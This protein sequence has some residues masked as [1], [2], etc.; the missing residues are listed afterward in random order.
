[1]EEISERLRTVASFVPKGA[2]LLDVGSDH[3][4]LPLYLLDK[5]Q[6]SFALAGEV[7]EGPY[8]SALSHV[9]QSA[10]KEGIEVRLAD[11]LAAMRSEDQMDAVTICGMGGRLIAQILERGKEGLAP[12]QRLILQ[13]NN[14]EDEVRR[15]LT[16]N[17]FHLIDETILEENGKIYEILVA[18]RGIA[19]L[20][21]QELRFGPK[22]LEVKSPIFKK[23]W[24]GEKEQLEKILAKVPDYQVQARERLVASIEAIEEVLHE[25]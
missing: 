6:I 2:R 21:T 15:W 23:R 12:I 4:Y 8:Q 3:A 16:T 18:E 7:V 9:A 22:L 14:G 1:M 11:G 19:S 5:G 25:G 24:Q 13:P 17:G 20:N 10:H